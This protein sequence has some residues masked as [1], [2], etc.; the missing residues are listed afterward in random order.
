[1]SNVVPAAPTATGSAGTVSNP[2]L[3]A[4]ANHSHPAQLIGWIEE[5]FITL[6]GAR[7]TTW[8]Y[9]SGYSYL[10]NALS[11]Y[12]SLM[13]NAGSGGSAWSIGAVSFAQAG[14]FPAG[15]AVSSHIPV[16]AKFIGMPNLDTAP[17]DTR[18]VW[19]WSNRKQARPDQSA[20]ILFITERSS[21]SLY[22][23]TTN[24]VYSDQKIVAVSLNST[25]V[26]TLLQGRYS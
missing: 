20:G 14:L 21:I 3:A 24:G 12:G 19:G 2:P 11:Q 23:Y 25:Y 10:G 4:N 1:M 16:Q 7:Y 15:R 26:F 5:D 9:G 18:T 6:E 17:D 13:L 8:G 22:V